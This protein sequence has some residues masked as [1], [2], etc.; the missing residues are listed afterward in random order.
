MTLS[1]SRIAEL[2]WANYAA[3]RPAA[4]VTPGLE[5]TLRDD[6]I[7]NRS[8]FFPVPDVNHAALLRATAVTVEPLLDEVT[9]YYEAVELPTTLYLSPAC[10]PADL[11]ARLKARGFAPQPEEEA[12]MI[13]EDLAA[14]RLSPPPAYLEIRRIAPDE[15]ET[16]A[17]VFLQAFEMP[18]AYAPAMAQLLRP[19]IGLPGAYHY[20]AYQGGEP[21]GTMSLL[22]HAEI[23]I[24]GSAGVVPVRRGT[25]IASSLGYQ[26]R[27]DARAEGVETVVLQTTAG[28][29]LE[30]FLRIVGFERGFTRRCYVKP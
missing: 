25:R 13:A 9:A 16:F 24:L 17:G 23:G 1:P 27:E 15:A 3:T 6:V 4:E 11:P 8:A 26:A 21:V 29:L 12:W 18:A 2:E 14:L 19:S 30:R 28:A 5:V 20:L 10:T 7:L 22:C